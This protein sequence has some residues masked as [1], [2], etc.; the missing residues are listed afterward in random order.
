[1]TNP[2]F[3]KGHPF[4]ATIG[5][6][7]DL[8]HDVRALRLAMEKEVEAVKARESEV[9]EYIIANLQK[10]D[11]GAAG[12]RYRVQVKNKETPRTTDWAAVYAHIA[13][14]GSFDLLQKRLSDRAVLDRVQQGEPVPGVEVI[15]VPDLSL[16]K[17]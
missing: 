1:M 9:R 12:L 3:Q 6:C 2:W 10:G 11:T 14:T 5:G 15:F 16:T 17:I 4:P 7:A 13:Q 8:L